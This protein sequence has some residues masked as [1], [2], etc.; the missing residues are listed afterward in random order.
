MELGYAEKK[1]MLIEAGDMCRVP[2]PVNKC[3]FSESLEW[4]GPGGGGGVGDYLASCV[5]LRWSIIDSSTDEVRSGVS[6]LEGIA[7]TD[8]MVELL[9]RPPLVA[10]VVVNGKE[11]GEGGE[12]EVLAGE[13]M[14]VQ[15]G[16]HNQ[17]LKPVLDCALS[18]RLQQDFGGGVGG[19]FRGEGAGVAGTPGG[20]GS[21]GEVAPEGRVEH[22][23]SLLPL[24]P[25]V[26]KLVVSAQVQFRDRPHAWRLA[27]VNVTVNI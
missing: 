18:V 6:G 19:A 17:L 22:S 21:L 23:T 4:S 24:T 3:S 14:Q 2:V 9:R 25:G 11:V 8:S 20:G 26:F 15:V 12:V 16:L 10:E 7:W 1:R 13:L 5:S 27:P